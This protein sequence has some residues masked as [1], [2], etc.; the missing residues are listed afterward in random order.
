MASR[1]KPVQ[2]GRVSG[3]FASARPVIG[4]T[5][6]LQQAQTGVWDV[7]ASFL[8]HIYFEGINLAGGTNFIVTRNTARGNG[9][10]NYNMAAGNSFGPIVNVAGVGDVNGGGTPNATVTKSSCVLSGESATSGT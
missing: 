5:T 3:S 4:L 6:Y 1:H 7:R 10:G 2:I 9:G 8:P